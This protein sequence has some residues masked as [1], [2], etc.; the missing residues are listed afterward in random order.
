MAGGTKG[1][2]GPGPAG[3]KGREDGWEDGEA[4]FQR[5]CCDVLEPHMSSRAVLPP[6][7]DELLL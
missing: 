6:W 2:E 1:E 7:A 4:P 5:L 3:W